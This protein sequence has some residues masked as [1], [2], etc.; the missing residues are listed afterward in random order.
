MY[1]KLNCNQHL[2]EKDRAELVDSSRLPEA[3]LHGIYPQKNHHVRELHRRYGTP[4]I[5][6]ILHRES[7]DDP[8]D[9]ED[10]YL[11]TYEG[12]FEDVEH[13]VEKRLQADRIEGHL[14]N[15]T[16]ELRLP[17]NWIVINWEAVKA[18]LMAVTDL[19]PLDG[20]V[21]AFAKLRFSA[22]DTTQEHHHGA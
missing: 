6:W 14:R 15:L 7:S 4:M 18:D 3:F 21:H 12:S 10:E 17:E 22:E 13:F 9:W 19:V 16:D 1:E 2:T 20:R 8:A 5:A 11:A